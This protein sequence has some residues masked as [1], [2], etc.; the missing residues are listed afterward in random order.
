LSIVRVTTGPT[1]RVPT[2]RCARI[3]SS[4][5]GRTFHAVAQFSGVEVA[6]NVFVQDERPAR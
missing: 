4:E 3:V 5:S 2:V 6:P 1:T